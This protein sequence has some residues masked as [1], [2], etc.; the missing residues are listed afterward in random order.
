MTS[1]NNPET[2]PVIS[3]APTML[4][5]RLLFKQSPII[6][7]ARI[8]E[9]LQKQYPAVENTG[10]MLFTFPHLQVEDSETTV[11]VQCAIMPVTPIKLIPEPVLQQ[12]W[13]WP[14]AAEEAAACRYELLIND[15]V[16][17]AL[18]YKSRHKLFIDFLHAV[19]T[20]TQPDV[21]YSLPA[22]KL[23]PPAQITDKLDTLI[24]V[25]LFN[26]SDSV[27]KEMFMD[28]VGLHT[29]GLPDFQVRFS[30]EDPNAM[31]NLL[32]NFAYYVFDKGDVIEDG[33][34]I[35]GV[36]PGTQLVCQYAPSLA[37]PAREAISL[38]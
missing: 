4:G 9:E 36:R 18:P 15:L 10:N 16:T 19:V 33:N 5:C 13:H 3:Y 31:A 17:K 30:N 28:T 24:N 1:S 11:H 37:A 23:L 20:V 6:D 35:E 2:P 38:L 29:F 7:Y 14:A 32:R 21:V 8:L 34:T 22:E 26:I 25:R 27:N 12:N